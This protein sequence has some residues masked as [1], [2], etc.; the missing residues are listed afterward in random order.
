MPRKPNIITTII[1]LLFIST[2]SFAQQKNYTS[3]KDGDSMLIRNIT[4]SLFRYHDQEIVSAEKNAIVIVIIN[5]SQAGK[6][7]SVNTLNSDRS[8][9]SKAVIDAI[10]RTKGDWLKSKESYKIIIPVYILHNL[11][12]SEKLTINGNDLMPINISFLPIKGVLL[13]PIF[14]IVGPRI[15]HN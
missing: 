4:K 6:I 2:A 8:M 13:K 3:Y 11:D 12:D 14:I 7:D 5:I 15:A 10:E 1:I 9:I